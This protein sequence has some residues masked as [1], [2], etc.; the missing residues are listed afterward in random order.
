[1][2]KR[3]KMEYFPDNLFINLFMYCSYNINLREMWTLYGDVDLGMFKG[4]LQ[5]LHEPCDN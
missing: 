3:T 5:N 1:M 4:Q 2:K